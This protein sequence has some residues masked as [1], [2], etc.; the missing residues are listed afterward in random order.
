MEIGICLPGAI[1]GTTGKQLLDWASRAEE[2]GFASLGSL[3]RIVY[4]NY[5]PLVAFGAVAAVTSRI[6]LMTTSLIGP[7]RSNTALFAKQAATVQALSDGRLVLG[8]GLGG[9]A[10]D[11]ETSSVSNEGRGA[12]LIKQT[13]EIRQIWSGENRGMAGA[14]G[15]TAA[16]NAPKILFGGSTP[17]ALSRAAKHA[18]G[19]IMGGGAPQQFATLGQQ[20]AEAWADVSRS[21]QPRRVS[22]A[23]YALGPSAREVA[24]AYLTNFYAWLGDIAK[25]IAASAAVEAGAIKEQVAAFAEAGCDELIYCPS[26]ADLQQVEL[27]AE[28]LDGVSL[29]TI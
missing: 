5:E 6:R 4:D 14:I 3:D 17:L 15:P 8:L 18:D 16:G 19:W 29:R 28:A 24:D 20:F 13:R 12:T 22:L 9:R 10:D 21:G 23:R 27:L 11:Y 1:P 7:L 25:G 26:A 2:L